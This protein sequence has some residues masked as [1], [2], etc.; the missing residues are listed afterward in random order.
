MS[1]DVACAR[2]RRNSAK[3][4]S[5]GIVLGSFPLSVQISLQS[6][7][8]VSRVCALIRE[9]TRLDEDLLFVQRLRAIR[10]SMPDEWAIWYC[11]RVWFAWSRARL[12]ITVTVEL[13]VAATIIEDRSR[14][15]L[16]NWIEVS[17]FLFLFSFFLLFFFFDVT[18][19]QTRRPTAK[20]IARV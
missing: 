20:S 16:R 11:A 15:K 4:A 17:L 10:Y 7:T 12:V 14:M 18:R 1:H 13:R 3:R 9:P 6:A 19:K 5:A 8:R 2:V